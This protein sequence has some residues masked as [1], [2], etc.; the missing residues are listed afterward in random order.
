MS[1][2][3]TIKVPLGLYSKK[4]ILNT[5][6]KYSDQ[7]FIKINQTKKHFEINIKP[8]QDDMNI[9]LIEDQINSDLVDFEL[10]DIISLQTADIRIA[11]TEKAFSR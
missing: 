2:T 1:D 8:K 4:A 7:L 11:L 3:F 9:E 5:C 10:R 6:Y